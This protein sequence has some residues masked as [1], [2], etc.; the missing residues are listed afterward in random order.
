MDR[1]RGR[2]LKFDK[3]AYCQ[4][5]IIERCI[6]W[7]KECRRLATR[8]ETLAVNFLAMAKVAILE[9]YLKIVFSDSA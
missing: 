5:S 9:R 6:G 1:H 8:F 4:R 2:P 3:A 7:L